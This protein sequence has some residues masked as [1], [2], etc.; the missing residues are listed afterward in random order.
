MSHAARWLFAATLLAS[1]SVLPA[2]GYDHIVVVIEENHSLSQVLGSGFAP[3]MD[4]LAAG[5]VQ[6]SNF[7][8][9]TH[10]SQPNYIQFYSGAD[11]GIK[12]DNL[13][14]SLFTTPN[15]GASLISGGK[16]FITYSESLPSI[17]FTGETFTTVSGQ[18]QYVRKHN[19]AANWQGAAANP[20]PSSSNAPFTSFP[21]NPAGFANLPSVSFVVPNEQNDMHDGSIAQGDTWLNTNLSAYANWAKT[22]N[23]LLIVTFDEDNSST[24]NANKIPTI[25]Y[26]AGL[27]NGT[28]VAT[29]YTLH[30]LQQT[31][32]SQF[33]VSGA[34]M[35]ANTKPIYG[36]FAGETNGI[37]RTFKQNLNGYTST[38]SNNIFN[39]T[40]NTAGPGIAVLQPDG[41]TDSATSGNQPSQVLLK[42]SN[43]IGPGASQVPAGATI[44]SAKLIL[45]GDTANSSTVSTDTFRLHRMLATWDGTSTW[46]SLSGGVTPNGIEAASNADF[47]ILPYATAAPHGIFDVT[48]TLQLWANGTLPNNGW[49]LQDATGTDGWRIF[50][51]TGTTPPS[52]EITYLNP[53]AVPEPASLSLLAG[54]ALVLLAR[55]RR[56]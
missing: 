45:T 34:G 35:A 36:A 1:I 38:L 37:S 6:F 40:P 14:A 50:G 21:T 4:S 22:N 12:N 19:P 11:Q 25:F 53:A 46:N 31:L 43:I 20:I 56:N 28:T 52:L 5:G 55:R 42:F 2:H 33:N 30:N 8:S 13:P 23:S 3:Y 32:A 27:R 9:I 48:D 49:L 10:P 47:E 16:T 44:L 7:F 41:D 26:G 51:E 24:T 18:N 29:T 15:L 39:A 54:G 17:G